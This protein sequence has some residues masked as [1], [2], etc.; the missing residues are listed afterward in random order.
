MR[1]EFEAIPLIK[2]DMTRQFELVVLDEKA[3]LEFEERDGKIFLTH[4]EVPAAFQGRGVG[5]ALVEK[6]MQWLEDN[7]IPLVPM[8]PFVVTYL[9]R[10]PE[11]QRILAKGLQ[12]GGADR[13][14]RR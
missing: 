2:N 7:R 4:A 12:V 13:Y 9:K 10:H 6:T 8:C 14:T 11:W 3:F 1:P 5:D